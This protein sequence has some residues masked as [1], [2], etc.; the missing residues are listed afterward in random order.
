M[1]KLFFIQQI[2]IMHVFGCRNQTNREAIMKI[3]F[4]ITFLLACL[5][6]FILSQTQIETGSFVDERDGQSYKIVK[7]GNQYWMAENLNFYTPTGSTYYN[8]D[9]LQYAHI[10]GRLYDW[11]T[12]KKCCPKGWHLSTHE[13]WKKLE[14]FLGI[15]EDEYQPIGQHYYVGTNQGGMLKDTTRWKAPNTGAMNSVAFSALAA[16]IRFGDD[17]PDQFR[18]N[19]AELDVAAHFWSSEVSPTEAYARILSKDKKTIHIID[20]DKSAYRSV[21]CVKD[22]SDDNSGIN[23]DKSS[24]TNFPHR[25]ELNQN[26]PNPFNPSTKIEYKLNTESHVKLSIYDVAGERIKTLVNSRKNA[27]NH[28]IT[29][30]AKNDLFQSISSGVY[31]C[32]LECNGQIFSR[33]MIYLK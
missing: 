13:D 31:F 20:S 3:K 9:S 5:P 25:I 11:N 30:D 29:W 8:N 16:G 18:Y 6:A 10:Y 33:Q 27:G 12:A 24:C 4:I 19:F 32:R 15:S 21:R 1:K 26:Y 7:I 2:H 14:L 17:A 28:Q 23:K 22:E